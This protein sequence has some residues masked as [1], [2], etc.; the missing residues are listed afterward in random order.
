MVARVAGF[1]SVYSGSTL[2][3][4]ITLRI[5]YKA[6]RKCV[7]GQEVFHARNADQA[8]PIIATSFAEKSGNILMT[9]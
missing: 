1:S 2:A 9:L 8:N 3:I 4:P 5:R 7:A 6:D